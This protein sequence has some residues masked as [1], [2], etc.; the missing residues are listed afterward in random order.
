VANATSGAAAIS[1]TGAARVSAGSGLVLPGARLV[2]S[3]TSPV[4]A[5]GFRLH[6]FTATPA[7]IP[8]DNAAFALVVANKALYLGF[9][10]FIEQRVGT[11]YTSYFATEKT[12]PFKLAS[13]TTLVGEL[14]TI[15]AI[16]TPGSA[17]VY[18]IYLPVLQN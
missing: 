16:T 5:S 4:A 15:G 1:I 3:V 11:D 8:A 2:R 6:L 12:I 14:E 17:E 18:D 7:T 10:E 9:I 13:G